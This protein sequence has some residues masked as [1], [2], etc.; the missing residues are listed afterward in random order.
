MLFW[1]SAWIQGDLLVGML[2]GNLPAGAQLCVAIC[3]RELS[4][5]DCNTDKSGVCKEGTGMFTS[6][7]LL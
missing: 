6:A 2:A 7:E 5:T 4:C 1:E 3:M